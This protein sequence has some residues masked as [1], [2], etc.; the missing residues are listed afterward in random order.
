[1]GKF[2]SVIEKDRKLY[3]NC[4]VYSP[5][6]ILMFRCDEKKANWYLNRNLAETINENP[7]NIKLKFTPK[8][9]GNSNKP[10]GLNNMD[11]ICVNCGTDEFLTRHHVVPYCYRRH[12]PLYL[13][14]H[15][16]HDV[17][18]LCWNCHEKYERKADELKEELA[19]KHHVSTNG[20]ISKYN[21]IIDG[22][23]PHNKI[24]LEE[25]QMRKI[26]SNCNLLLRLDKSDIPESRI[27]EVR[28]EIREFIG[29]DFTDDD[30]REISCLKPMT[31]EKTHGQ[32]VMENIDNIQEFI[33]MWRKHFIDNNECKFMPDNWNINN[34]IEIYE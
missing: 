16:F 10:F 17:L 33:E 24:T 34:V 14:S 20:I 13:K 11:N 5:D 27:A 22:V 26:I 15:N 6:G 2:G 4:E 23:V 29:H 19:K 1:M 18:S 21:I 8:G 12:F 32:V 28:Q 9:L 31:L 3:G 7:L 30:M 25:S